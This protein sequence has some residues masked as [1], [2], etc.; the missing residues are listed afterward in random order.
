MLVLLKGI[1]RPKE[2][3]CREEMPFQLKRGSRCDVKNVSKKN[4][5]DD[6]KYKKQRKPGNGLANESDKV[7]D[8]SHRS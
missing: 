1:A 5:D 4:I 2:K 8:G 3:D 6:D 7:V